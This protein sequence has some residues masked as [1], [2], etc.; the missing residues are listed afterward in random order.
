MA[1]AQRQQTDIFHREDEAASYLSAER[2]GFFSVLVNDDGKKRQSS[3]RL[4]DMPTVLRLVD[5]TKDSWLTQAE[6]MA[7]NRRV[8]NLARVGLLFSDLDTYRMPW[9]AGKTPDQ[10]TSAVLHHCQE[11]GIPAPSLLIYS[12]RGIQAK[13]L[14]DGP[15]PRQALPRW[16][17]CQ[18][19]LTDRLEGMGSDPA[20]RDASRVL[21]LIDTVN[22][23]SGAVCRVTHITED[24]QGLPVRYGFDYL[25]EFLLPVSRWKLEEARKARQEKPELH[26]VQG[27]KKNG[28]RTFSARQLSWDRLEDLRTLAKLR[29]GVSEGSRMQHLFWRLN[30]LLL[31][32]A[33]CS[34]TMYYEATELARQIDSSWNHRSQEL[35]T[36][37]SKAKA[38]EAGEKVEFNGRKM[39]ALYTPKN[40]TLIGL[41]QI[42]DEEQT[43]LRTII[44]ETTAKLRHAKRERSR[45]AANGAVEKGAR[46]KMAQDLRSQG[47]TWQEIA[48]KCGYKNAEAARRSSK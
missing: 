10:L 2:V 41:F 48:D 32:G 29:G 37:Y 45:R 36:L 47:A 16:N 24:G 31:S 20:A 9:A 1:V 7:P 35:M 33:V 39:P 46:L 13:W 6:F 23:K 27:F 17:A 3:H 26:V 8:V 5:R 30:F 19:H 21:R 28:L 18:R 43:Q 44:S 40:D 38:F 11:E 14:L 4:T 15:V 42:T 12:G 25:A 34:Q 22:T